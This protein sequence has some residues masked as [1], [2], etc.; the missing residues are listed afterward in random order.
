MGNKQ[1]KSNIQKL[2]QKELNELAVNGYI[3]QESVKL[4]LNIPNEIIKL[5]N[6][7]HFTLQ[8]II[9]DVDVIEALERGTTLVINYYIII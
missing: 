4:H 1:S 5:V 3:R 6:S 7:Y 2:Y 9:I 8:C